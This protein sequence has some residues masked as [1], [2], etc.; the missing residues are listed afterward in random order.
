MNQ[1]RK[2]FTFRAFRSG[3]KWQ[4]SVSGGSQPRWRRDGKELFYLSGDRRVTSVEVNGDATSFT[5]GTPKTRFDTPILKGEDHP[6]DQYVVA[7]M[8][9]L[10]NTLA[11][12]SCSPSMWSIEPPAENDVYR[13]HQTRRADS[14]ED[15]R[16]QDGQQRTRQKN[17][18]RITD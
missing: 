17:P 3:A 4:I 16:G 12:E 2:R 8:A 7:P 6:G 13:G 15:W 18:P 11:E 10:V 1:E 14:F 9:M 5:H